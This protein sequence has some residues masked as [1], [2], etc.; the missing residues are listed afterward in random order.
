MNTSTEYDLVIIGAGINGLSAGIAYAMNAPDKKVLIIEKNAVSGGYVTTFARGGFLFDTCQMSS[1]VSDILEYFGIDIAFHDFKQDF[2][3]VFRVD[4]QTDGIKTFEMHSG[5]G[6]FEKQFISLF[7]DDA[8]KLKRFF[9]YSLA[10]FR[11][12]YGLKYAPAFGDILKML[13]TCPK[14]I[15]NKDKT[16]SN[17]LRM[18]DIDNP[19]IGLM[20]QVFSSMC[21]LPNDKI[22]ALLTV[23]VMYS[24]R[25]KAYRPQKAFIE[26]PQKMEKRFKQ[27]GGEII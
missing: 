13:V 20:F 2:I 16:F 3:R 10:M 24:L 5:E 4:P 18:F 21:G 19:E 1:N 15:R 25:E 26:L 8:V 22:A 7:P 17:Y 23:G 11:E 12:I 6:E 9:A 14:V 27:L